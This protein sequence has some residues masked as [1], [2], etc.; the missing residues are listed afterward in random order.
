M[1][2][3][4]GTQWPDGRSGEG[5]EERTGAPRRGGRAWP[6]WAGVTASLTLVA[7]LAWAGAATRLAPA[8]VAV[9]APAAFRVEVDERVAAAVAAARA[10]AGGG[11]VLSVDAAAV[12]HRPALVV[13][14][15]TR[16]GARQVFVDA[17]TNRI[18]RPASGAAARPGARA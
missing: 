16:H 2:G 17:R 9:A 14:L 11:S 5:R 18:L 13:Q 8:P 3:T 12:G 6:L 10:A 4:M 1:Q 15:S 7:A